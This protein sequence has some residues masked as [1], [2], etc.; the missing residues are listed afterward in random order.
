M[1]VRDKPL[2]DSV[3][4]SKDVERQKRAEE[5]QARLDTI[6][7]RMDRVFA[8]QD[9]IDRTLEERV[10]DL[11]SKVQRLRRW[12]IWVALLGIQNRVEAIDQLEKL[13]DRVERGEISAEDVF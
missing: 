7:E 1:A 9:P 11:E 12:V 13:L 2:V 4:V 3:P 6:R 10:Q 8:F 5:V